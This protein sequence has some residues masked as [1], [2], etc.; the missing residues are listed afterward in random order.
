MNC[1]RIYTEYQDDIFALVSEYFDGFIICSGVGY[2]RDEKEK[3]V[4]IEILA[5]KD[6]DSRVVLLAKEIKVKYKQEEAL[7]TKHTVILL[8]ML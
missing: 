2:W 4:I 5:E 6:I 7:I 3:G 8:E 1:Y